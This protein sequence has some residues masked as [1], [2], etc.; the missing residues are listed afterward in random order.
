VADKILTKI[1]VFSNLFC[2]L[3]FEDAFASV[4][5]K[6]KKRRYKIVEVKVLTFFLVSGMIRI[7]EAQKRTDPYPQHCLSDP[8]PQHWMR[9]ARK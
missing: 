9:R 2:L 8:D 1:S 5:I 7:R 6:S 4:F 3:I